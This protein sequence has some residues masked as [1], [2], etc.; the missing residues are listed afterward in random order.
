MN[1]KLYLW[2]DNTDRKKNFNWISYRD[3]RLISVYFPTKDQIRPETLF[4]SY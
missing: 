2:E 4:L 1:A 3:T